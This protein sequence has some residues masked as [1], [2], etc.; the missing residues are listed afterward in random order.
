MTSTL[1]PSTIPAGNIVLKGFEQDGVY[2]QSQGIESYHTLS[3]NGFLPAGASL[4][5]VLPANLQILSIWFLPTDLQTITSQHHINFYLSSSVG[6][7]YASWLELPALPLKVGN[8]PTCVWEPP[9]LVLEQGISLQLSF[10][11]AIAYVGIFG[12]IVDLYAPTLGN[13]SAP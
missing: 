10:N 13:V 11:F 7:G 9:F 12:K 2:R 6:I 4:T 1:R 8:S 3:Q 5:F